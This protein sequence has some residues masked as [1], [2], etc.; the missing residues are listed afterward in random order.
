MSIRQGYAEFISKATYSKEDCVP[1][2]TFLQ[3]IVL[4]KIAATPPPFLFVP[5]QCGKREV[6]NS[7]LPDLSSHV[8]G[9]SI[10]SDCM[11]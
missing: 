7:L 2:E 6:I 4:E 11:M 3:N 8:S 5:L 9:K 10:Q 1:K